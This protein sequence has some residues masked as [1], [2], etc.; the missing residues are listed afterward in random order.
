MAAISCR[1]VFLSR[2]TMTAKRITRK[3]KFISFLED[4][5]LV[6]NAKVREGLLFFERHIIQCLGGVDLD[7]Y[8]VVKTERPRSRNHDLAIS[9][10]SLRVSAVSSVQVGP[11]NFRKHR[12]IMSYH[13][14]ETNCAESSFAIHRVR[15]ALL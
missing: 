12:E 7:C 4:E 14:W 11:G 3:T 1:Q 2:T 5:C 9:R 6:S 8:I 10:W 13:C 15:M